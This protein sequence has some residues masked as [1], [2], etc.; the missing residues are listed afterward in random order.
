M[1]IERRR[2]TW[3]SVGP[4]VEINAIMI[5]Q[6]TVVKSTSTSR[7]SVD[8]TP[9]KTVASFHSVIQRK[10]DRTGEAKDRWNCIGDVRSES[11]S[12]PLTICSLAWAAPT[13]PSLESALSGL[14]LLLTWYEHVVLPWQRDA[15]HWVALCDC[16]R[17]YND[18]TSHCVECAHCVYRS[19]CNV[20]VLLCLPA[21]DLLPRYR[22]YVALQS[23]GIKIR[24]W[25]NIQIE[26]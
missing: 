19:M 22:V 7:T 1:N 5:I 4:T 6:N 14:L 15:R 26:I 20:I 2:I 16:T 18:Q 23:G 9:A 24:Y 3:F 8:K 25:A 11:N 12:S 17:L 21:T 10:D 13:D